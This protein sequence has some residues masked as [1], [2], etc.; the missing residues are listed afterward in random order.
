MKLSL[1]EM[2]KELCPRYKILMSCSVQMKRLSPCSDDLSSNEG[3]KE[4]DPLEDVG[5]S[6]GNFMSNSSFAMVKRELKL[7]K[8]SWIIVIR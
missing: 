2:K 1:I 6:L 7:L 3:D 5:F 8:T 4:D